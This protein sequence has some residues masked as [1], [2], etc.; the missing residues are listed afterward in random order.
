MLMGEKVMELASPET[1]EQTAEEAGGGR[2]EKWKTEKKGGGIILAEKERSCHELAKQQHDCGARVFFPLPGENSG[3]AHTVAPALRHTLYL[4]N[5][6][7][8]GG[9]SPCEADQR[10]AF[11]GPQSAAGPEQRRERE[12]ARERRRETHNMSFS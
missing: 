3:D 10:A 12:R 1:E 2:R 7:A 6:R 11:S 4:L 8:A 9:G 5:V